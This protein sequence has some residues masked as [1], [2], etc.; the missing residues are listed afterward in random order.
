[1]RSKLEPVK[2]VARMLRDHLWGIIN[3]VILNVNNARAEN[4][5]AKIQKIKARACGFRNRDRFRDAIYFHLGG[6]DL[7][8]E[9][10]MVV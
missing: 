8:P 2:K 1:M 9:T 10:V 6:L 3:A 7:Y 4:I 5:N